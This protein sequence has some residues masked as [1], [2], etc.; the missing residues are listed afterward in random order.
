M[1]AQ[2]LM[3]DGQRI[4]RLAS[5]YRWQFNSDLAPCT[6]DAEGVARSMVPFGYGI[7]L[8]TPEMMFAQPSF[9][10][11]V[12]GLLIHNA[13][14]TAYESEPGTEHAFPKAFPNQ[15]KK[16]EPAQLSV[17]RSCPAEWCTSDSRRGLFLSPL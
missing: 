8:D 10:R 16:N 15:F 5:Q 2:G 13:K 6:I 17:P 12:I 9:N 11:S 1:I 3:P 14:V 4:T 7:H